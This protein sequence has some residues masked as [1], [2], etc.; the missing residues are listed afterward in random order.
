LRR[1]PLS[2]RFEMLSFRG[3]SQKHPNSRGVAVISHH[4]A[5]R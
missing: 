4:F 2:P 1:R 5:S 3:F